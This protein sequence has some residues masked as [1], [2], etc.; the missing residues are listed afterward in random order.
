MLQVALF[1]PD[2]KKIIEVDSENVAERLETMSAIV[3]ATGAYQIEVRSPE[4]AAKTGRYR[5][6]VEELR[7]ATVKDK[8]R[9]AAESFFS[10][11]EAAT[12]WNARGE[13]KEHRKVS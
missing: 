2:D 4:K 10:R 12:K 9:V 5:I 1:A 8:Y 6:K 11:G 13:K 3:E 7:D